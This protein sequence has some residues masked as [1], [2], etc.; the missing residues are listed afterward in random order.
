MHPPRSSQLMGSCCEHAI[1]IP[2]NFQ[3]SETSL[4]R[5]GRCRHRLS[6]PLRPHPPPPARAT[7]S[8]AAFTGRAREQIHLSVARAGYPASSCNPVKPLSRWTARRWQLRIA[9]EKTREPHRTLRVPG[10]VDDDKNKR[11]CTL[12]GRASPDRRSAVVGICGDCCCTGA[13]RVL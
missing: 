10:C 8:H 4:L 3:G 13:R 11:V 7:D 2:T 9:G 6:V 5:D 12:P 1:A